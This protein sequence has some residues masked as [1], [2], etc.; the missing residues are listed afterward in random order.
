MNSKMQSTK[1]KDFLKLIGL[2]GTID[3]LFYL[4]EYETGQYKDF[5]SQICSPVLNKRLPQLVRFGLITHHS[6]RE[7]VKKEWYEIA[8]KGRKVVEHLK[9]LIEISAPV[10]GGKEDV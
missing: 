1:E 9:R 7:N 4:D 10:E 2:S 3:I 6:T 5:N 8:E